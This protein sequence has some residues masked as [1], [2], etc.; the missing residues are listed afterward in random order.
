MEKDSNHMIKIAVTGP[1]STGKS[2]LSEQLATHYKTVWVKE[3]AR[4]YLAEKIS[5]QADDVVQIALMQRQNE[6][7]KA[8][9]AKQ[10]LICDTDMLVCKVWLEIV[11]HQTHE[12]IE[13]LVKSNAYDFT[14]LC[15]IDLP[16]QPDPLREH[17]NRREE[18]FN[19]YLY[20]LQTMKQPF[21]IVNGEG[22]N[23]LENAIKCLDEW[24]ENQ[25]KQK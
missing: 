15:D 5:Y 20:W 22:Q 25:R 14:L 10:L 2:W 12:S 9:Q 23:R 24:L 4:E 3:Y 18:I 7:E 17:P 1:E 11:F 6:L 8:K 21:S 16:W 19:R 13:Q